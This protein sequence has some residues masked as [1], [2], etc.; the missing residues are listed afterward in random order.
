[1]CL[2]IVMCIQ[3]I[4]K[5]QAENL[6]LL[7]KKRCQRPLDKTCLETEIPIRKYKLFGRLL[8]SAL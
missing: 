4:F 8:N 5:I 2:Y 7:D 1:M 6:L 3:Q